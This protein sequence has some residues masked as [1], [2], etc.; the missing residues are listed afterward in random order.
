MGST[1][2]LLMTFFAAAFLFMAFVACAA[3]FGSTAAMVA[4]GLTAICVIVWHAKDT[5]GL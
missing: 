1:E 3:A 4:F 5:G 2:D